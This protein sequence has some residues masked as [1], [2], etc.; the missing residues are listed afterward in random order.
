MA[1][2]L[3]LTTGVVYLQ[4]GSAIPVSGGG[5]GI[6][7]YTIGDLLYASATTT[8]SK[9][10]AVATGRVLISN[11][12]GVAPSWSATPSLT[13]LTLGTNVVAPEVWLSSNSVIAAP[14]TGTFRLTNFANS[15]G[16]RVNV[17]TDGTFQVLARATGADTA[18]VQAN[19][20]SATG[21][22]SA[23]GTAGVAAF[24]PAAVASITVKFGLVTAI[25]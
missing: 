6:S 19:T 14:S 13:S 9:L 18:T 10:A 25:S 24:G 2:K 3:N 23:N 16:V 5:T 1:T 8:L 15:A 7:S 21:S 17:N 11:G 12:V 22:F 20:I 4:D